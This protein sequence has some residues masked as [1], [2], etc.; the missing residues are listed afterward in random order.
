MSD[1]SFKENVHSYEIKRS[2]VFENDRGFAFAENPNAPQPFVTWQFTENENG[3]RDY[4]WGHYFQDG[5]NAAKDLEV[6]VADYQKSYGV[7]E[8]VVPTPEVYKYYSTQRPI[9]LGTFPK[10]ENGPVKIVNFNN[11][12]SVEHGKF[13]AWG[14]L[15]YRTPLSE[16]QME[17]Y[18]LRAALGNPYQLRLSPEQLEQHVQVIGKWEQAKRITDAKRLTWWYPDFGVFV[19]KEFITDAELSE[20]YEKV[21]ESKTRATQ[22]S[23]E[24]RPI[25]ELLKEGAAQAERDNAAHLTPSKNTEKDR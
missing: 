6:R 24:N 12:E 14:Y 18:E 7:T 20:L 4:Y 16:K 1:N 23:T 5:D 2:V 3:K 13:H 8:K 9:D 25:A 11:C 22:K 21:M 19:K 17:D 15:L 10:T